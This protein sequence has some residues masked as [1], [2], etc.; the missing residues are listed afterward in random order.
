MFFFPNS[1]CNEISRLSAKKNVLLEDN[2][3]LNEVNLGMLDKE[4]TY[5]RDLY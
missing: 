1:L 4:I 3:A 2:T 5:G